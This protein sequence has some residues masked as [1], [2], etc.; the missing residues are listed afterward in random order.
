DPV[1]VRTFVEKVLK[2]SWYSVLY[3]VNNTV[4]KIGKN[5][6]PLNGV[7]VVDNTDPHLSVDDIEIMGDVNTKQARNYYLIYSITNKN[8]K[9]ERMLRKVAVGNLQKLIE[10]NN[11]IWEKV[12]IDGAESS[13]TVKNNVISID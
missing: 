3:G 6:D 7:F 5:F 1:I 13:Y 11:C 2:Q 12:E 4:V 8:G 9:C 10:F